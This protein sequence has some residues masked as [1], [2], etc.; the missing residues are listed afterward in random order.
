MKLRKE[1]D[2]RG[3]ITITIRPSDLE[4]ILE[5]AAREDRST[6]GM[7]VILV[8]EALEA[9]KNKR[10]VGAKLHLGGTHEQQAKR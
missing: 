8:T 7:I 6:S 2:S 5:E 1:T 4:A 3:R 10:E 9:R